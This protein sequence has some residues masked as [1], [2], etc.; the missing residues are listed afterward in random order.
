MDDDD[1]RD[2]FASFSKFF[3]DFGL[4]LTYPDMFGCIRMRSD[5]SGC[6]RMHSDAFGRIWKNSETLVEKLSFLQFL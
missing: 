1:V 6:V 5:T 2:V 4:A 3:E